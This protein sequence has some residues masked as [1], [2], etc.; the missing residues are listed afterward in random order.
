MPIFARRR[1]QAMLNDL[2]PRM[3]AAD[4]T[5]LLKRLEHN[6]T[7]SAL[8]AEFELALLWGI[9][10]SADLQVAPQLPA[11]RKRPDALSADLFHSGPAVIE[12]TALSDDTFSGE[13][14]MNRAANIMAQFSDRVRKSASKHLY[15]EFQ[16]QNIRRDGRNHRIRRVTKDFE[17]TPALKAGL[18]TWLVSPDWPTPGA[19][20]L[21][22][23]Q[24][25]VIV[26]WKQYVHP[27]F[28]TFSSMP[29]VAYDLEDNHIF[30]AL[31]NKEERQLSGVPLGI[32]KCIFLCD[33]GCRNLRH[34][35]PMGVVEISGE[36]IIRH[37]LASSKID[38]VCV[39]SPH[40]THHPAGSIFS[41]R[42]WTVTVFDRR[43]QIPEREYQN[44]SVLAEALP[45]P[46]LEGNQARSLHRQGAFHPQAR[47]Q[48][49]GMHIGSRR[50]SMTI[51]VSSRLVLELL[52][53]RISQEQFRHFA[54]GK[55]KNIFEIQLA[56]GRTIQ[57]SCVEKAGLDKDDDY[58]VFELEA[59][60]A[61]STLKKPEPAA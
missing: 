37:F 28:R 56:H 7:Q 35:R 32:L 54:F 23:E 44:L 4:A 19:I 47:G 2:G 15:F 10:R 53:G 24:V 30:K 11:S 41:S 25:D 55:D 43:K 21:R 20:R 9:N 60:S 51:K 59:D 22:D 40:S 46:S 33:A 38:V 8:A 29:A 49:L 14:D 52:A 36:K 31:R 16:E 17:L 6:N 39:F 50:S 61:A 3:S 26:R 42:S 48:Y 34:L 1:L 27:L 45:R 18:Q 13:A 58:L 57:S 5:D 12:I